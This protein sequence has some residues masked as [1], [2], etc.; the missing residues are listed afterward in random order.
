MITD[1]KKE[2]LIVDDENIITSPLRRIV[3]KTLGS[4]K[5]KYDVVTANNPL[6]ALDDLRRKDGLDLSLVI[7]DIM[8]PQMN[9]LDFLAEVKSLCPVA[10][11]IVLT[12]YAD[13]ENAIRALNELDL[14]YYVEKPWD[15]DKFGLLVLN[16]LDKYRQGKMEIMFRRYVPREVIEKFIDKSDAA[17]LEGKRTEATI[18]FLDIVDFT[19]ITEK[20][21]ARVVVQLLNEHFTVMVDVIH[22]RRGILDKFTGDGLLAL[23]GVPS[24]DSTP[25]EDAAN[26]VLAALDMVKSISKLNAVREQSGLEPVRI[27]IGLDS[28]IVVAGNIGCANRVNY[29]VVGDTVNTAQRIE[30]AARYVI[31]D[32]AECVLISRNTYQ[33][34]KSVLQDSV[35]FEAQGPTALRGKEEKVHLYKVG[36]R[37]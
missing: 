2:I 33:R 35:L 22:R 32:V 23:F 8:M 19:R 14:F 25:E 9:G 7:A 27:R 37:L 36:R 10:P 11:R 24:S 21:D 17:I 18:L 30:D 20:M 16:A 28:G 12:G 15:N 31:Q 6:Q 5:N 29:T 4:N 26:G 13:K 34:A 3:Q 1:T